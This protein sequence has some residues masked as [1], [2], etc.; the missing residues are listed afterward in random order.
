[1]L[2]T[3]KM[4]AS[5]IIM[6]LL[7]I[8]VTPILTRL[9]SPA[10]FG[11]WGVFSGFVTIITVGMFLCYENAIIKAESDDEALSVS[12]LCLLLGFAITIVILIVFIVG[13]YFEIP[14]FRDFPSILLLGLYFL[15]YMVYTVMYNILNRKEKYSALSIC[16]VVQGS[17]QM[18]FRLLFGLFPIVVFNGLILGTTIA[19]LVAGAFLSFIVARTF[20]F[21]AF[22]FSR[23]KE[24]A[25]K[26]K[27]FAIYDT[28]S[29]VLSF[30]AFNLP[31]LI[32]NMYFGKE[33]IGC[34]SIVLQ[35]LLM[36]MSFF[37]SA[38]S[39]V[40]YQQLCSNNDVPDNLHNVTFK[41]VRLTSIVCFLPM[42]FLA[43]GGDKIVVLFL[44]DRWQTAATVSLCMSL[45][46][47]PILLTQPLLPLFRYLNKLGTLFCYECS[48]FV[49]SIGALLIACSTTTNLAT[50]LIAFAVGA[51][52]VKLL[53][54]IRIMKE[55][56]LSMSGFIPAFVMW[57]VSIGI[58][59]F[60][61][62]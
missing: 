42:L 33:E 16:N 24:V 11:E 59:T 49:V 51:L 57:L 55:S 48:Y 31:I 22:D 18:G 5:N 27:K 1:M 34:F 40:Y 6:Y 61:L 54:F 10:D 12:Y 58:L 13:S 4:S 30:A 56:S 29:S 60:R 43:C 35:L 17:S 32:L 9:Y 21:E 38:M 20:K 25:R 47:L 8:V 46:S 37:G 36:P 3:L 62:L 19:Q 52:I 53:L 7:P 45:W 41:V 50:I 26:F 2:N 28:P 44:G 23:V 15:F 14:F 39:R